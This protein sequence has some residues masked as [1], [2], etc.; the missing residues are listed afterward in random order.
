MLQRTQEKL[1]SGEAGGVTDEGP[2]EGRTR[3][4]LRSEDEG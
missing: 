3:C 4:L 2:D 1:V